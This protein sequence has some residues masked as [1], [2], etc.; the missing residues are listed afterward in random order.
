[1]VKRITILTAAT[2]LTSWTASALDGR[3]VYEKNCMACHGENGVPVS[4]VFPPLAESEWVRGDAG[5][6]VEI[7][8]GGLVG[9]ITVK[10]KQYNL[11]MPTQGASMTDEEI[12][13]V[14]TYV[15][16]SWGNKEAAVAPHF[17]KQLRST[18]EIGESL[19]AHK[20]LAK[21]PLPATI[22]LKNCVSQVMAF[23]S[24]LPL[25]KLAITTAEP[26]H[27][28]H[29]PA[30]K[31]D[32][33]PNASQYYEGSHRTLHTGDLEVFDDGIYEF[34]LNANDWA[35]VKLDGAVVV[36]STS[37]SPASKKLELKSG[38]YPVVVQSYAKSNNRTL[39]FDILKEGSKPFQVGKATAPKNIWKPTDRP[40]IYRN[41]LKDSSARG[42]AIGFPSQVHVL[43]DLES[44]LLTKVW[45]GDFIDVNNHFIFR[46]EQPAGVAGE[47]VLILNR[48]LTARNQDVDSK[49]YKLNPAGE[50]IF[51]YKI[52]G[53]DLISFFSGAA[54]T[55][56][57]KRH[58]VTTAP[59]MD[60]EIARL[61]KGAATLSDQLIETQRWK[62]AT[63]GTYKVV[64]QGGE[65]I[66]FLVLSNE[67]P[68]SVIY[69]LK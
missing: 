32:L 21:Y 26:A 1:M 19:E 37:G 13:A 33:V 54:G 64:T 23:E 45:T 51:T 63:D 18:V 2:L 68:S 35:E 24:E 57:V 44:S 69:Q 40:M 8:L 16:S 31:N 49:G 52:G 46:G 56:A 28:Y 6:M 55:N 30:P 3:K 17:V 12:A 11:L 29:I 47:D 4:E 10:G 53:H 9:E 59:S 50:P 41:I 66:V 5:R 39:L 43:L 7:I 65:E 20:V 62:I 36:S 22:E 25:T 34:K 58:F 42:M 27:K 48:P 60:V 38:V 67:K 14:A 61:K 15:R